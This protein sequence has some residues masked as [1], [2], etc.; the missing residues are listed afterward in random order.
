MKYNSTN[1]IIMA[2]LK[3]LD[4]IKLYMLPLSGR[5]SSQ[6]GTLHNLHI[7]LLLNTSKGLKTVMKIKAYQDPVARIL[8]SGENSQ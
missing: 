6:S 3:L 5:I 7:P 8:E 2:L 1:S 4:N